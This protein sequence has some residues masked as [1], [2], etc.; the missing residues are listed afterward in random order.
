MW[1]FVKG[2]FWSD[3]YLWLQNE[4]FFPVHYALILKRVATTEGNKKK[5]F[6]VTPFSLVKT[7]KKRNDP[8]E[9][10]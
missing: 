8:L 4:T 1:A 9:L 10:P 6:K 5:S 2:F 3:A 7:K